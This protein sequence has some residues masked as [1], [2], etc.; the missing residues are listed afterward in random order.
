MGNSLDAEPSGC[1]PDSHCFNNFFL[2]FSEY[3]RLSELDLN[4]K[5]KAGELLFEKTKFFHLGWKLLAFTYGM[6]SR[7]IEQLERKSEKPGRNIMLCLHN[8]YPNLTVYDFC[9]TLRGM[10]RFDII[11][12]LLDHL[13]VPAPEHTVI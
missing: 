3:K 10:R 8:V 1:F 12:E 5:D 6:Q 4:T 13:S 7:D 2:S 11:K 9:K